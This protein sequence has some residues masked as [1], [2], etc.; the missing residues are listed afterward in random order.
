MIIWNI[1][2]Y[3]AIDFILDKTL[4]SVNLHLSIP[5]SSTFPTVLKLFRLI[6]LLTIR[7]SFHSLLIRDT[8]YVLLES[9]L[10]G[11]ECEVCLFV[12]W[13]LFDHLWVILVTLCYY[14]RGFPGGCNIL[15]YY[16]FK[17]FQYPLQCHS[18][19]LLVIVHAS[20][21]YIWR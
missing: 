4:N 21:K 16:Y 3:I 8:C 18:H 1:D 7:D 6:E 12:F 5:A 10:C 2:M 20:R 15:N 19:D 17:S 9:G 13:N 14:F 11:F